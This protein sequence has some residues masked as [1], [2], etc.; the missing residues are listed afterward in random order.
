M[1]LDI[2]FWSGADIAKHLSSLLEKKKQ[3]IAKP[4]PS[5]SSTSWLHHALFSYLTPDELEFG[6]DQPS[7]F[8]LF[9]NICLRVGND[10][11]SLSL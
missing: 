2:M 11:F 3:I 1:L 8:G 9:S 5:S 4:S 7:L 10:E 6:T